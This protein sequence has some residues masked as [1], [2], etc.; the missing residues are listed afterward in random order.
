MKNK[1]KLIS[2][3]SVMMVLLSLSACK[4]NSNNNETI[5][6]TATVVIEQPVAYTPHLV[7]DTTDVEA[8]IESLGITEDEMLPY[9]TYKV[10][11]YINKDGQELIKI[12]ITT[13]HYVVSDTGAIEG[14][15]F[16]LNDAFDE[17]T[18]YTTPVNKYN[19]VTFDTLGDGEAL[20]AISYGELG[21]L[22]EI[23]LS[24]GMDESY[25]NRVMPDNLYRATLSK[26]NVA[27]Y[28]VQLVNSNNRHSSNKTMV[29]GN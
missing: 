8:A 11:R 28:Y 25:V 14:Y 18:I 10:F 20:Y 5:D 12:V 4:N 19:K 1:T 26:S 13:V 23:A 7:S 6:D 9:N 3:I 24:K 17:H 2:L 22:K 16:T 29:L 21:E 15:Y 27:S